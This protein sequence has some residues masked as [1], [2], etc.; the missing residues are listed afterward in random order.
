MNTFFEGEIEV[1]KEITSEE[2]GV[3][4]VL[5]LLLT[6]SEFWNKLFSIS[7]LWFSHL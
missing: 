1:Q 4:T 6:S 2:D 3:F 7:G 5:A